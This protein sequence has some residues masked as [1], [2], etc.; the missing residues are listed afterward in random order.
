MNV[1]G[2]MSPRVISVSPDWTVQKAADVL[3]RSQVSGAPVVK[4]GRVVGVLSETDILRVLVREPKAT[5]LSYLAS[6]PSPRDA[7]S[8]APLV[9]DAMTTDVVTISPDED[10]R[11]AAKLMEDSDVNRLPVVEDGGKVVGIVARADLVHLIA[12]RGE[13]L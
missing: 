3:A 12:L 6:L 4:G 1:R 8:D 7:L 9:A 5:V 13:G 11:F 10:I 2:A